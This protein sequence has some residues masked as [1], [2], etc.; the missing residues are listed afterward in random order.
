MSLSGSNLAGL[1]LI[2][3]ICLAVSADSVNAEFGAQV[4]DVHMLTPHRDLFDLAT[5]KDHWI[6]VGALGTLL[7]SQDGGKNWVDHSLATELALLAIAADGEQAVAVGQMGLVAIRS[8]GEWSMHQAPTD[9]RLLS[10]A[11]EQ[12]GLSVAV[13]AFG[14]ILVSEDAGKNWQFVDIDWMEIDPAGNEPHL[15]DVHLDRDRILLVGE[16]GMVLESIDRGEEWKLVRRGDESLFALHVHGQT[17]YAVGQNG[18]LIRSNGPGLPWETLRTGV[19]A[20]LLG[21]GRRDESR[22]LVVAGMRAVLRS[23]DGGDSWTSIEADDFSR[24]WYGNAAW[25]RAMNGFVIMGG[26]GQIKLIDGYR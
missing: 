26:R 21:I 4:R 15:Y 2:A 11:T 6:A 10:V 1:G 18:M 17:T 16:F 23:S 3:A 25:S 14:T 8:D 7:E 13:G 22:D 24:S 5:D 20:N 19:V 9:E 12:K